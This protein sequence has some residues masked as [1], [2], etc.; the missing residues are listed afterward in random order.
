MC[1]VCDGRDQNSTRTMTENEFL[2]EDRLGVIRDTIRKYGEE[3]FYLSFSGGKDSTVLHHLLDMAV[4]GN[5]IPRVF[6]NTG[7]EFNAVVEFVKGLNDPRVIIIHPKKNVR[8]TLEKVGYPFKSKEYSNWV[9]VYQKHA[10][11]IDPYFEEINNNPDLLKDWEYVHNLPVNVKYI[12]CQFYGVRERERELHTFGQVVPNKL[13]YQFNQ[14]FKLK[15]SD[16][17][18]MEFKEKPLKDWQKEH[19]IAYMMLGIM[20]EEGGRRE[21]AKCVVFKNNKMTRF[22]P[23][24]KVSKEWE[25]WFI[26]KYNIKLCKLYYPPYNFART[27]CKGCPYNIHISEEL[28]TLKKTLPNEYEQCNIIWKPVYNEYRRIGY[29]KMKP[30]E[31]MTLF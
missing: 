7:I 25:N 5:N 6:S 11:R 30:E 12:V 18:C 27:G 3:N 21:T 13:K 4:P 31:Q 23:L 28:E 16:Q 15:V 29:R 14:D 22:Q 17:C 8:Q 19:G 9:K 26:E 10:D 2:L 24:A 1:I 20:Q